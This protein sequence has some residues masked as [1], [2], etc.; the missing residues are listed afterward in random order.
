[1]ELFYSSDIEGGICRLD[2]DESGHCV[3]VLRHRSGDE[4]SVIDG[5]GTLYRCRIT[6]DSPKGVEA[7]VLSSEEGWGGHPYHLHMAVC[8]T[9]N[10][11][12][13]EWFAEKACEIGMDEVSPV[14][15]EHSERRVFKTARIGKILVSAA[16][17]S[18]KAAV[19]VVNE[20]V[21]VKEFI[22]TH[23]R[24]SFDYAQEDRGNG[25]DDSGNGQEDSRNAQEDRGNGQE[26]SRNGQ[27]D[28]VLRMIAYCFED[29][30][31]PRRSIREVLEGFDGSEITI[32]IGPEG[33]FSRSE[34]ELALA[35]GFI[36]VHLGSSRLRTETAALTAVSAVYFHHL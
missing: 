13:Y 17:Q 24:R 6:S 34:A 3:K 5:C 25:Q 4:I 22:E 23:G 8:P 19:P 12:R 21:S 18:L 14:I 20:P 31:V 36:P 10:N 32:L 26:D 11:D 7:M 16:K 28:R 2:Q 9:K 35:H 29:E 15:G 30:R 33:D 27:E 1:M